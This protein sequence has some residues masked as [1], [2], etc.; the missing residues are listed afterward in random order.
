MAVLIRRFKL[1]TGMMKEERIDQ[2]E[3]TVESCHPLRRKLSAHKN[4]GLL[5]VRPMRCTMNEWINSRS[6]LLFQECVLPQPK[7]IL[8]QAQVSHGDEHAHRLTRNRSLDF[9]VP[10]PHS[11]FSLD[12]HFLKRER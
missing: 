5:K 10:L 12:I 2:P 8:N 4:R 9:S 6:F 1:P 11:Y 3:T 7:R